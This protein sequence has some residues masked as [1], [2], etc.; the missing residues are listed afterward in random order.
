MEVESFTLGIPPA[1]LMDNQQHAQQKALMSDDKVPQTLGAN[2]A[3]L[4]VAYVG[5]ALRLFSR[6]L[7]RAHFGVDDWLT[8]LALV[9]ADLTS[10]QNCLLRRFC[11]RPSTQ[12]QRSMVSYVRAAQL[13]SLFP[14]GSRKLLTLALSRYRSWCRKA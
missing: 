2:I 10:L 1:L 11:H 6:K 14:R 3:C 9:C 5:V 4:V 13:V 7:A 8:L 12:Q